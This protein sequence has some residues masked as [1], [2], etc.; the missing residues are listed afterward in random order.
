MNNSENSPL[1]FDIAI[2]ESHIRLA[3]QSFNGLIDWLTTE[4]LF[5]SWIYEAPATSHRLI[6]DDCVSSLNTISAQVEA[7]QL[8]H[9]SNPSHA[10]SLLMQVERDIRRLYGERRLPHSS[11]ILAHKIDQLRQ[12]DVR[13]ALA[14]FFTRLAAYD[15][16]IQP[17]NLAALRGLMHGLNDRFGVHDLQVSVN[18]S[19]KSLELA[20]A[21]FDSTTTAGALAASNL[22]I[23]FRGIADDILDVR[24]SQETSYKKLVDDAVQGFQDTLDSHEEK[25]ENLRRV[26][27]EG[28]SLRAPVE[29]WQ[30]RATHHSNRTI[31]L[32][33]TSFSML[34]GLAIGLG[35]GA[36]W[37]LSVI[38]DGKPE[39]W[40][41]A[42]V[43][44]IGVLGVWAS[45]LTI[46]MFLSHIHL[47]TDANE[48]VTMVKTYLA[49]IEDGKIP[50]DDDRKLI[51]QCLF[52]PASDGI[53][54]D[55]GL[56]HP[57]LDVLTRLG[58][59]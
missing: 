46:R 25:L 42:V 1:L 55:E 37:V 16:D 38:N 51:L 57:A 8:H 2:G 9:E 53:V 59:K 50:S 20:R 34:A 35:F 45:R 44:L 27:N 48:R 56:P 30:A 32:G 40:R 11:T 6:V 13:V 29:Y 31:V 49:L 7:A 52:R 47:S 58:G 15:H 18:S 41:V 10:E 24:S 14:Y 39:A 54:K 19:I 33:R 4:R 3:P 36:H 17:S 22:Q 23:E 21:T 28:M 43:L 12:E 26:F 5:W